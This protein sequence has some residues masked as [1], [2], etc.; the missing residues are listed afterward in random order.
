MFKDVLR[1]LRIAANLNQEELAK[2]LGL[3]KSTISMYESGSREPNFEV[4]EAIADTF[5]VDMNTLIGKNE[6][7]QCKEQHIDRHFH[8]ND[9]EKD[10]IIAYRKHPEMQ[11]AVDTL[12]N[13]PAVQSAKIEKEA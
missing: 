7:E 8:L 5:N 1:S 12:L 11:N 13:V 4:L 10:V 6:L 2:R 3:A 9:H